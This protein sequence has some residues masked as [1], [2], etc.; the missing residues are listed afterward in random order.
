MEQLMLQGLAEPDI[1][2]PTDWEPCDSVEDVGPLNLLF[3]GP[4]GMVLPPWDCTL[5]SEAY[6]AA[7][8]GW[9]LRLQDKERFWLG[10]V[11]PSDPS[12]AY[13]A[14]MGQGY[15]PDPSRVKEALTDK[16]RQC[17]HGAENVQGGGMTVFRSLSGRIGLLLDT[18]IF[19]HY[20][21][22]KKERRA[23]AVEI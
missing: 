13:Y 1:V 2:E 10:K 11:K 8:W 14:E 9:Y 6:H 23:A 4:V 17:V 16:I 15:P 5:L 12:E 20:A 19:S 7:N 3:G 21:Q 18:P 22:I